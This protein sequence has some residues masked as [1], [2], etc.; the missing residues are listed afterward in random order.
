MCVALPGTV[1]EIK[2]K[3]AIVDFNGNTVNARMGLVDV[4]KGDRVLV[5]AGCIIQKVSQSEAEEIEKLF[6]ELEAF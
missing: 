4:K 5:H 2:D 3:N 6:G 1:I